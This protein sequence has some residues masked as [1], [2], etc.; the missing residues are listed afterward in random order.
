MI[1]NEW[2][3]QIQLDEWGLDMPVD[4]K[5]EEAE[6][7]EDDYTEPDNLKVDVVLGDLIEIGEHRLLC[8]DS[9]DSETDTW[10]KLMNG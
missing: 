5:V 6:A 4:F 2:D 1:A 9:S 8:G 10:K 3:M 7:E